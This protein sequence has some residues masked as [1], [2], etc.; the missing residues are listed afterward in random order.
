MGKEYILG[1]TTEKPFPDRTK[2]IRSLKAYHIEVLNELYKAVVAQVD[3]IN[4]TGLGKNSLRIE[5]TETGGKVTGAMHLIPAMTGRAP[6]RIPPVDALKRWA[7]LKLGDENLAWAIAKKIE[8]EGTERYKSKD[9][10]LDYITREFPVILDRIT[11]KFFE[12][13]MR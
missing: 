9:N 7:L 10:L 12:D 11:N 5:I 3:K 4:T 6:G 13:I 1:K 2:V 8:R